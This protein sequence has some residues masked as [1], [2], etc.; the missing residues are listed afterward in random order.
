MTTA[1]PPAWAQTLLA[2]VTSARDRDGVLGDLLEEFSESVLPERGPAAANRWY[3]RQV[4]GF[5]W[6][7]SSPAGAAL[8]GCL[9]A[10]VLL[11]IVTP[12]A[13]PEARQ[14]LTACLTLA[15]FALVGFRT[16]RR[17]GRMESG[18]VVAV[19][20]TVLA[21]AQVMAMALMIAGIAGPWIRPHPAAWAGLREGFDQ[22]VV[23]ML[24]LGGTIA[25]LGAALGKR[26]TDSRAS[27]RA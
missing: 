4:W 16:G 21:T 14:T 17:T 10:R 13:L 15:T 22:P 26:F 7:A 27:I 18:A 11:D 9:C 20:A 3:W 25:S 1:T 8:G 5:V 6:R 23:P 12:T 2:L 19:C 24:L